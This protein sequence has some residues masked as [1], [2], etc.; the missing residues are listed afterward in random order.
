MTKDNAGLDERHKETSG[1]DVEL[2]PAGG[3]PRDDDLGRVVDDLERRVTE[4][5]RAENVS[6][7]VDDRG[8]QPRIETGDD[9]PE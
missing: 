4:D 8:D 9:A 3:K 2:P 5:R 1:G 7:N 6:G